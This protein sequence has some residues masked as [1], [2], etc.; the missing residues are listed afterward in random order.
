MHILHRGDAVA[1]LVLG[2]VPSL[3]RLKVA[4]RFWNRSLKRLRA[5]MASRFLGLK[6]GVDTE[7]VFSGGSFGRTMPIDSMTVG[8]WNGVARAG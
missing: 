1:R 8:F 3:N 5:L 6:D 2:P 7:S 4:M